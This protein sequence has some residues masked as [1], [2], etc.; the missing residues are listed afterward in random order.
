MGGSTPQQRNVIAG[1]R[2]GVHDFADRTT[3]AGNYIGT[4]GTGLLPGYGNDYG[5]FAG[6]STMIGGTEPGAAM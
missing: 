6:T 5:I 2:I 4:D 1:H 3:I